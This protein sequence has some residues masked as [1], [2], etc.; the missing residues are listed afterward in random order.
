MKRRYSKLFFLP[1][2]KFFLGNHCLYLRKAQGNLK[3]EAAGCSEILS[4]AYL[5][6]SIHLPEERNSSLVWIAS[7]ALRV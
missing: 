5:T 2:G 6:T 7:V 4:C 3:I 1:T